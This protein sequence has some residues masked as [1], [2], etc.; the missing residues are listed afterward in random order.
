MSDALRALDLD[1]CDQLK[2]WDAL[3]GIFITTIRPRT[4]TS[5]GVMQSTVE[6]LLALLG[7]GQAGDYKPGAA[8]LVDMPH[9][10]V[11]KPDIPG[12]MMDLIVPVYCLTNPFYNFADGGAG[13]APELLGQYVLQAASPVNF[14]GTTSL[15]VTPAQQA[16]TRIA[17]PLLQELGLDPKVYV[18]YTARLATGLLVPALARAGT[19]RITVTGTAFPYTVTLTLATGTRGFYSIDGSY[20]GEP[21]LGQGATEYTAPFEIAAPCVLRYAAKIA[22]SATV[23]PSNVAAQEFTA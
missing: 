13:I 3:A 4:Q 16:L 19:P 8:L 6:Q 20:P 10:D 12:P 18:G 1:V 14:N 11:D 7:G 2:N 17:A 9:V 23:L 5:A 15:A 22:G 21:N